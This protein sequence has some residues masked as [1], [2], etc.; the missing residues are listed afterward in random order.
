MEVR[1]RV[2]GVMDLD[3]QIVILFVFK[4]LLQGIGV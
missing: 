4:S 1:G 3:M 2:G